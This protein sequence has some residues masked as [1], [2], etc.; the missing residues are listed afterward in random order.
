MYVG[1]KFTLKWE[2][3]CLRFQTFLGLLLNRLYFTADEPLAVG[4]LNPPGQAHLRAIGKDNVPTI[5][6]TLRV[7]AFVVSEQGKGVGLGGV[8]AH[9]FVDCEIGIGFWIKY[10]QGL[11][12]VASP[13]ALRSCRMR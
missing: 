13:R 11:I 9:G 1:C 8:I 6:G 12:S 10:M 7:V 2:V 4:F 5:I 3:I